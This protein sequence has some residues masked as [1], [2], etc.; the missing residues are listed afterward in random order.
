MVH[1]RAGDDQCFCPTKE[2]SLLVGDEK[3][4]RIIVIIVIVIIFVVTIVII[5]VM[6]NVAT[7]IVSIT[8]TVISNYR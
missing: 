3:T 5:N 1:Q 6:S 2:L 4:Y 7:A 8:V